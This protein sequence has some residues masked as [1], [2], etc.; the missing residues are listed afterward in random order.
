MS[1]M[2]PQIVGLDHVQIEAP[3]GSEAAA[4]AFYGGVLGLP[5]V[6]KP[7]TLAALGGVWFAVGAQQI[8]IGI[9]GDFV[10]RTKGHPA[11]C[12]HNLPFWQARISAAGYPIIPDDRLPGYRRFYTADPWGNRIEI[13]EPLDNIPDA[14][15]H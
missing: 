14:D 11:F 13:L 3:P 10:P 2:D 1:A 8:H 4:R 5:E 7:A 6:S 9:V 12:V 15:Q